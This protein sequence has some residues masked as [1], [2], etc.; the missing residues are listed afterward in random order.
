[1]QCRLYIDLNI[2]NRFIHSLIGSIN[3]LLF[4]HSFIHALS[5]LLYLFVSQSLSLSLCLRKSLSLYLCHS[6]FGSVPLSACPFLNLCVCVVSLSA[7][8]NQVFSRYSRRRMQ[9]CI[10]SFPTS[11]QSRG[12]RRNS[13]F[14]IALDLLWL[15]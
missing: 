3:H 2:Y 5:K 7:Y 4:I 12:C 15:Q 9:S 6:V 14:V 13:E 1:M 10:Y 8:Y 11:L